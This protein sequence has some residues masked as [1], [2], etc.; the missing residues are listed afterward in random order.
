MRKLV[1]V[2]LALGIIVFVGR[3]I[4][5]TVKDKVKEDLARPIPFPTA[6]PEVTQAVVDA[7]NLREDRSLFVP[8]WTL[9]E[10]VGSG[11]SKLIYF[12]ITPASAG[13]DKNDEGYAGIDNFMANAETD[14]ERLLT[15]TMTNSSENSEILN[16]LSK[17]EAI[18][19]Q[20][21]AIARE[22]GFSGIVLNLEMSAIP[23]DSLVQQISDFSG[24]FYQS[25]RQNRLKYYVAVYGDNFYRVR[26]FD[27]KSISE[28]SDGVLVMAY[29]FHKS[30]SNPGPNFPLRGKDVY[31]YD[32]ESM[33]DD[34]LKLVPAKKLTVI[35]GYFG[36]D[37]VVDRNDKA[38]GNGE[39][40]SYQEIKG[41]FIDDCKFRNCRLVRDSNSMETEIR[42]TDSAGRNHIV[43]FEDTESINEKK[44][45]LKKK[46]ISSFS[47]FANSYF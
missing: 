15:V 40:S 27:V 20:S 7:T 32:I 47:F 34:Y 13:I 33:I 45:L 31:G 14:G 29:D 25:A 35:F 19:D 28:K 30:R 18:I 3:F 21:I 23:F 37:W 17:Q 9:E 5:S 46:G 22:K 44:K 38:T 10:G 11:Y 26:P 6:T 8:Y 43:W 2:F 1:F 12:G 39:A 4:F 24:K 42:Y 16:N 41:Q 36:Y